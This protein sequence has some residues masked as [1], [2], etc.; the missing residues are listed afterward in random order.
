MHAPKHV[1]AFNSKRLIALGFKMK[2]FQLSF[3]AAP[4]RQGEGLPLSEIEHNASALIGKPFPLC[5]P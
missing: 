3:Q 4:S 1:T 5:V 2:P